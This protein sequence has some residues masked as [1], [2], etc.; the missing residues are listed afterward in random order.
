[1]I[2]IIIYQ[3]V[4]NA[5]G[6]K[7]NTDTGNSLDVGCIQGQDGSLICSGPV[8]SAYTKYHFNCSASGPDTYSCS[9]PQYREQFTCL[10]VEGI[11]GQ[12]NFKC[13]KGKGLRN[14]QATSANAPTIMTPI[15]VGNGQVNLAWTVPTAPTGDTLTGYTIQRSTGGGAP[16]TVYSPA[17]TATSQLDTGLTNGTA[18]TYT[19]AANYSDGS[20]ATS[21]PV[22]VTPF[23]APTLTVTKDSLDQ[24]NLS[25]TAPTGVTGV[26][27]NVYRDTSTTPINRT[28]LTTTTYKD[29]TILSKGTHTYTV[30]A[31]I[32]ATTSNASSVAT[33]APQT[34]TITASSTWI[35]IIIILA[36]FIVLLVIGFILYFLFGLG[37]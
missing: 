34:V 32:P 31:I 17:A 36:I 29:T 10:A 37:E 4:M 9:S 1:M 12:S 21:N 2:K 28:P 22:T 3:K 33:S 6:V 14:Y 20:S 23:T 16:V 19:I 30:A 8:S 27:Y 35:W 26:T 5:F 13:R 7:I 15:A 24:A 11:N 18:Y 25:W